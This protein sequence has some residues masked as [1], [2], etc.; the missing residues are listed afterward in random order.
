M[1]A[2]QKTS[3]T[4]DLK[5][6]RNENQFCQGEIF[7][8]CS[9]FFPAHRSSQ[10]YQLQKCH[11]GLVFEQAE[12]ACISCHQDIHQMTAGNDLPVVTVQMGG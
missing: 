11:P 1:G 4:E 5:N 9:Y 2:L 6:D 3:C 12:S 10:Q 7:A 8:R